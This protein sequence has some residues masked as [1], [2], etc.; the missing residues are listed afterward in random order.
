MDKNLETN[1]KISGKTCASD[2]FQP[3]T[4]ILPEQQEDTLVPQV[5]ESRFHLDECMKVGL[6]RNTGQMKLINIHSFQL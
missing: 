3:Q 2:D 4:D 5:S 6:Q 1:R